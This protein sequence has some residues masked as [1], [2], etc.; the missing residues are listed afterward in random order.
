MTASVSVVVITNLIPTAPGTSVIQQTIG[1]FQHLKSHSGY[2]ILIVGD[3]LRVRDSLRGERRRW[4]QYKKNLE[5]YFESRADIEFLFRK[6]WGHIS[7]TLRLALDEITSD[8]VLVVQHDLPFI[9]DVNLDEVIHAMECDPGLKH[10]RFNLRSN[11]PAGQ[12]AMTTRRGGRVVEDRSFF[13]QQRF[14][15]PPNPLPLV[16]TL[17]WSDNNFVCSTRYLSQTILRPIGA[18]RVDPEWVFNLLGTEKN[19]AQLGTYVFGELGSPPAIRH[20][21]GR[22]AVRNAA[23]EPTRIKSEHQFIWRIRRATGLLLHRTKVASLSLRA[24]SQINRSKRRGET[25]AA[26]ESIGDAPR[27]AASHKASGSRN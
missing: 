22:R 17:S 4:G 26:Q 3:G 25:L 20:T 23:A 8:Y 27:A 6:T 12:D 10:I 1:S 5:I 2:P 21:D 11:H 18:F 13:F 14:G 24:Q 9:R 7:Q 16:Q 15:P 19:H